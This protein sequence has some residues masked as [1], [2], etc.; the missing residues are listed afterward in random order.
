MGAG[1]E[2]GA[3]NRSFLTQLTSTYLLGVKDAVFLVGW[4]LVGSGALGDGVGAGAAVPAGEVEGK[5]ETGSA[6]GVEL[7]LVDFRGMSLPVIGR[8]IL[9]GLSSADFFIEP[10]SAS[11]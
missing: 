11:D 6:S 4:V 3:G 9:G 1:L 8:M 2:G 10:A 7:E 5:V